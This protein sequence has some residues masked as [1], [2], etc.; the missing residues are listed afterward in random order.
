[1]LSAKILNKITFIR[2]VLNVKN[3]NELL[4]VLFIAWINVFVDDDD[5]DE[6]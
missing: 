1:M 4:L 5:D 2:K 3:I 6:E